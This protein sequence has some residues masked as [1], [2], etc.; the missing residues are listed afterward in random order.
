MRFKKDQYQLMQELEYRVKEKIQ[1]SFYIKSQSYYGQEVKVDFNALIATA[2]TE[3][4]VEAVQFLIKEQYTQE[5]FE[6]DMGLK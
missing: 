2:V 5:N 1:N 4:I 3:G 6:E